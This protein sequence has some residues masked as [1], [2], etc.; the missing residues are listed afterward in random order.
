MNRFNWLLLV[1]LAA[2]SAYSRTWQEV[3]AAQVSFPQSTNYTHVSVA[4]DNAYDVLTD[5]D[6]ALSNQT[7][8]AGVAET[9]L[10]VQTA[11]I[12]PNTS[13]IAVNVAAISSNTAS[14]ASNT[15]SIASITNELSTFE[16]DIATNAADIEVI[17][18][19][20][21]DAL[22]APAGILR[23]SNITS[24]SIGTHSVTNYDSLFPAGSLNCDLSAGTVTATSKGYYLVTASAKVRGT[25]SWDVF[26]DHMRGEDIEHRASILASDSAGY[27]V[28]GTARSFLVAS[29]DFFR[30]TYTR[31]DSALSS[32]DIIVDNVV[33][34]AMYLGEL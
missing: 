2:S 3:P 27:H 17:G 6:T 24:G 30:I 11:L 31:G 29:N 18:D 7:V 10:G 23:S 19:Y 4:S 32:P 22:L 25:G 26:V 1:V 12:A 9:N 28:S 21:G 33:L 34:Q 8:R 16:A 14:I 15:A 13:N 20:L 5:L